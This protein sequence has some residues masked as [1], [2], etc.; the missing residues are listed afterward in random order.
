MRLGGVARSEDLLRLTSAKR[1]RSAAER[2]EIVRV[3]RGTYAL[4]TSDVAVRAA[5]LSN[6]VVTHLSA[7][8]YWG[9]E[10]VLPPQRPQIALRRG[11]RGPVE[12]AEPVE[13]FRLPRRAEVDGPA[14]C[15]LDTVLACARDL[16]LRD[17]LAVAD[18]ALRSGTLSA[19]SLRTAA[20]QAGG[21]GSARVRRVAELADG[22][23]ANAFESALRAIA[24]TA[25]LGV[26]PQFAIEVPGKVL[27]PDL[28]DPIRSIILEADS[29]GFHADKRAHDRDCAR[30]NSFVAAGWLVLR[31]TWQHVVFSPQ[32]VERTIRTARDTQGGVAGPRE[33]M[34]D[35]WRASPR[36]SVG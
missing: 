30:Y 34:R 14:T 28:A 18:S 20:Q 4:P 27:H 23:A 24:V 11:N 10:V 2:G 9:W 32:Y 8:A 26:I 29:W 7:A 35:N 12:N 16:P 5:Q 31:F 3:T 22:R 13:F 33:H 19:E 36:S 15:R 1:L 25:G 6:G 21:A 17:S